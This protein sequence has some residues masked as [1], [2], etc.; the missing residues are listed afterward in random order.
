MPD[1]RATRDLGNDH[2]LPLPPGARMGCGGLLMNDRRWELASGIAFRFWVIALL[3]TFALVA[4]SHGCTVGLTPAKDLFGEAQKAPKILI[5]KK[6]FLFWCV[7][8]AEAGGEF[9]G[10]ADVSFN[11][12]TGE[13]HVKADVANNPTPV[14][15]AQ[16]ALIE[17]MGPT[18]REMITAN[19]E[20][21]RLQVEKW[22][23]LPEILKASGEA[24]AEVARVLVPAVVGAPPIPLPPPEPTP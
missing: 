9:A 18:Q 8:R 13:F 1:V 23:A 3:S 6:C 11:P 16:A 14:V 4:M 21:N 5:E 12:Q 15:G 24:A 10:S 17:A 22:K 19:I 2:N 7:A 20:V